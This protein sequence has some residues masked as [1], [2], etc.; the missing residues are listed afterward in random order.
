MQHCSNFGRAQLSAISTKKESAQPASGPDAASHAIPNLCIGNAS[1]T[2]CKEGS[3]KPNVEE[4]LSAD[5]FGFFGFNL[6]GFLGN[7]FEDQ[8]S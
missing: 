6:L 1:H 8:S 2:K 4:I 5:R 7:F 3:E